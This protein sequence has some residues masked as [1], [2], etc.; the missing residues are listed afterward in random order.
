MKRLTATDVHA[1]KVGELGLDPT[2]VNLTSTEAI[3]AALR[4]AAGY[5]CP[6]SGATLVRD[7]V[8]PLRGLVDDLD[9]TKDLVEET[10]EA[11]IAHGDLLEHHDVTEEA[12]SSLGRLLYAAPPSFVARGSGAVILLGIAGDQLS[13]L[14][15]D[16]EARI[17]Y[18]NHVRRLNPVQGEDLRGELSQLGLIEVSYDSWLKAPPAVVPAQHV[19]KLSR[20]LDAAVPSRDIP[21]LV[22]LDPE[23]PVVY[24][25]GRWVTPR[26]QTGRFVGRRSQAY[27]ADLWCYVQLRDGQPERLIDLPLA[28][29]RWRGSDEA[30]HLQLAIDA[31]RGEPQRFRIRPARAGTVVLEFF[32]PVPMWAR[33]RWDAIGEPV[34]GSGCLFA[35][36]LTATELDEEVRFA[37]QALWLEELREGARPS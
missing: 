36:R 12:R 11:T 1:R 18:V 31:Q 5:L 33:R 2:A 25:R 14:P 4:R 8:R 20:M 22:L 37:S 28:S 10:L 17:E 21:G 3:A 16:I 32:S 23:R 13:V 6:C 9:A 24:Y 26:S 35:Y 30:W 15:D 29:S 34:P 7:V 19:L 27:G